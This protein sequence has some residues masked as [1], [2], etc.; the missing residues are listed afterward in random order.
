MASQIAHH[1][2]SAPSKVGRPVVV[3]RTNSWLNDSGRLRRCTERHRNCV[4]A[5]L[6]LAVAIVAIRALLKA[7]RHLYRWDTRPGSPRIRCTTDGRL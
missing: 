2:Q 7:V 1:G 6:S 3:D 4:D 5:N